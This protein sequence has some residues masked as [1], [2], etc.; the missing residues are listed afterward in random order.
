MSSPQN[1]FLPAGE[2]A[3]SLGGWASSPGTALDP[4]DVET[5]AG[6][7]A[8]SSIPAWWLAVRGSLC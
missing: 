5:L 3:F 8:P 4:D 7:V 1:A 6:A 2:Q